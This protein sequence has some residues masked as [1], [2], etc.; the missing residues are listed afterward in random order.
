LTHQPHP[1]AEVQSKQLSKLEQVAAGHWEEEPK[2][3]SVEVQSEPGQGV[4]NPSAVASTQVEL[5][6]HQK[7]LALAHAVQLVKLLQYSTFGQFP[8][9]FLAG[10]FDFQH[11]TGSFPPHFCPQGRDALGQVL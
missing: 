4:I 5:A 8:S 1:I 6:A 10:D 7:Q 2:K 9:Q 11:E 3:Q